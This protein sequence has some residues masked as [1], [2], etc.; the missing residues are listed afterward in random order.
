[1]ADIQEQAIDYLQQGV[2]LIQREK[3]D[4]AVKVIKKALE[5]EPRY[6]DAYSVLAD[7]YANLENYGEALEIQKKILILEPER[8]ETYFEL[9]NLYVM[10][11]DIVKALENYNKAD[12]KGYRNY[13]M[14][15]NLAE[16]YREID[17]DDL[18][19]RNYNKAIECAPLRADL[20]LEKAGYYI[21]RGK[22]NEA[23][24]T[25]ENLQKIEPDL[26]D[27]YE[28]R[29]EIYA[30][31]GKYREALD[32][33]EGAMCDYPEDVGLPLVKMRILT[34]MNDLPK[35]KEEISAIRKMANYEDVARNVLLQEAQIA[36]MEKDLD[37]AKNA[38]ME[39][40]DRS[41][42]F[43]EEAKFLLL[44]VLNGQGK[45]DEGLEI[46]REL[47][48][49]GRDNLYSITGM[50]Y[51][52]FFLKKKGEKEVAKAEFRKLVPYLRRVTVNSPHFYEAY[53]YRLMCH[54]ELGEYDKA[55]E[56]A[57]YI[58]A[59]DINSV[60]S[61]ALRYSIYNDMGDEVKAAEMK[62][63]VAKIDPQMQL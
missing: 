25:L 57:D 38:L 29:A 55:L 23:L 43:D 17:Q 40:I 11:D 1:M 9:G 41:E 56:L 46:A 44:N 61:Y 53:L 50:Y 20:R 42:K 19:F 32:L 14:Y 6:V 62:E 52:P 54:K 35:V 3:Y 59:L 63:K 47:S 12:E 48:K 45:I 34:K 28:M 58:E 8:G 4:D 13:V 10:T 15:K 26:F 7:A 39:I 49:T 51:V 37:K 24:E 27:A 33:I 36:A 22:F 31:L 60:D 2:T 18:V 21:L 30:G 16:I 5:L